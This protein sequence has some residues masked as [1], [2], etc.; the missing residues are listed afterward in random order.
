MAAENQ[1]NNKKEEKKVNLEL[2]KMYP[3]FGNIQYGI[4]VNPN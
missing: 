3:D 1:G 4:W 2:F